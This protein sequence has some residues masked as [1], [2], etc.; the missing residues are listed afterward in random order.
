MQVSSTVQ[1]LLARARRRID[2]FALGFVSASRHISQFDYLESEDKQA[3]KSI[4]QRSTDSLL[5]MCKDSHV[6]VVRNRVREV[7]QGPL[8]C[9]F[10]AAPVYD[11]TGHLVGG[12]I[13]FN[14]PTDPEFTDT[15]A[16]L[17]KKFTRVVAKALALHRDPLTNLLTRE[18][19]E[20]E[21]AW[22]M[23]GEGDETCAV[24]YG[25]IDQLQTVNDLWGFQI[26][27]RAIGLVG[28]K[29]RAALPFNALASRLGS[30]RFGIYLPQSSL[31]RAR[32]LAERIKEVV[33]S[34]HFMAN[35][36]AVQ[37]SISWG[38]AAVH[39]QEP[40]FNHDLAAAETACKAAKTR[41]RNRV[42]GYQDMGATAIRRSDDMLVISRVR[43][44]LD[45]E[46]FQVFGQPISSLSNAE[47]ARRYEML[48]RM[49]D[50]NDKLVL[51]ANFMSSAT[52]YQLLP[53]LDRHV[54]EYVLKKWTVAASQPRFQRLQVS[55]NLSSPSIIDVKFT[56]WLIDYVKQCGKLAE[57]LTFELT[58]AA[59]TENI[60]RTLAL[61]ESL[62]ALGCKFAIDD[63]GTGP[64]PLG[65]LSTLNLS[66]L[67]IDG[68]FI[69]DLLENKR[70]ESL[71]KAIAQLAK[72]LNIETV[73]KCV[74]SS[75]VCMRLIDLG[76]QSGQGY[77]LGRPVPL[78]R[79][80]D[81]MSSLALAS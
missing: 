21:V 45:E 54:I 42:E 80:L 24:I 15:S 3:A 11:G 36:Q 51:P 25:D 2:C 26:G 64:N 4:L 75:A 9:R 40:Q 52:R 60:E 53:Q 47:G 71:V 66:M 74:E 72:S 1:E 76:V 50:E 63:F 65:Y 18:S 61:V 8:L 81:P 12:L 77:A 67:K 41:G 31:E 55:L 14:R 20:R 34:A 49:I 35:G 7:T 32:Q 59:A 68:G 70:S 13:A 23:N 19:F 5:S 56:Q 69:R 43:E 73:A 48:V 33:A 46:R 78:E 6:P 57:C 44:A 62:S 29:I 30:D 58:E 39:T 38:I 10:L 79:I 16:R 28:E 37:I 17:A 27:D 22:R